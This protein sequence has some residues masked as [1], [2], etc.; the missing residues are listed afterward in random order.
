[1]KCASLLEEIETTLSSELHSK[2]VHFHS[3]IR[4]D[5]LKIESYSTFPKVEITTVKEHFIMSQAVKDN[6]R[7]ITWSKCN[8]EDHYRHS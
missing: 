7:S 2:S 3:E 1:M 4:A 5:F 6:I 8:S